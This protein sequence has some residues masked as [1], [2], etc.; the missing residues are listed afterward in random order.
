M[1]EKVLMQDLIDSLALE[2]KITKREAETFIKAVFD[3]IEEAL[4]SDRYVKI[5]GLGS[6]KLISINSRES[7]NVNTGERFVI[8]GHTRISFTPDPTMRD[9]INK[10]FAHFETVILNEGVVFSD[11]PEEEEAEEDDSSEEEVLPVLVEST[12][13]TQPD[14]TYPAAEKSDQLPETTVAITENT[15]TEAAKQAD[16]ATSEKNALESEPAQTEEIVPEIQNNKT[17]NMKPE[18]KQGLPYFIAIVAIIIVVVSGTILYIYNP[19]VLLNLLPEP[20]QENTAMAD[21]LTNNDPQA[22]KTELESDSLGNDT[23]T[24]PDPSKEMPYD[25]ILREIRE[26]KAKRAEVSEKTPANT[27]TS[28]QKN[29]APREPVHPDSTGYLIVGTKTVYTLQPGE[30]LVMI[31]KRFYGT[32]DLWPYI[33]R[34]NRDVIKN[35]DKVPFGTILKVPELKK[36]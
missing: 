28:E 18:D 8:E 20:K 12:H 9:L 30:T 1:S 19:R 4:E 14:P 17:E 15:D 35:P 33:A 10:P 5:K 32:K 11:T 16:A 25:K 24:V 3:L 36:K 26:E 7:V 31:S 21:S 34:H 29:V 27:N 22:A 6:F 23:T 2:R 13:E